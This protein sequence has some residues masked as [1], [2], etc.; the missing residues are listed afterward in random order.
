MKNIEK[1]IKE[2]FTEMQTEGAEYP[3][4][5][6]EAVFIID[7]IGIGGSLDWYNLHQ[8]AMKHNVEVPTLYDIMSDFGI[9]EIDDHIIQYIIG[10]AMERAIGNLEFSDDVDEEE[11]FDYLGEN[12]DLQG[13]YSTINYEDDKLVELGL[14]KAEI[15]SVSNIAHLRTR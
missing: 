2:S 14:S 7:I 11:V 1:I 4:P 6:S 3:V 5:H 8:Y 13:A 10:G 15:E 9:T 12:M